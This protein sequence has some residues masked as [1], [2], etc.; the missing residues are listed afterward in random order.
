MRRHPAPPFLIHPHSP[1]APVNLH[2][3]QR[4]SAPPGPA[5]P[6]RRVSL[7][8]VV[9]ASRLALASPGR[10]LWWRWW[11]WWGVGGG[12]GEQRHRLGSLGGHLALGGASAKRSEG[13][14]SRR[15]WVKVRF[16]VRV[17]LRIEVRVRVRA[18]SS[19]PPGVITTVRGTCG[20][21]STCG[22]RGRP[23]PLVRTVHG[24]LVRVART[25]ATEAPRVH[26]SA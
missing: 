17:G 7:T 4:D 23:A 11:W 26:M 15:T 19:S 12:R 5:A 3:A 21:P 22:R 20:T 9:H 18:S 8:A 13:S 14:V 25:Y 2:S 24:R 1:R 10:H 6:P 16:R